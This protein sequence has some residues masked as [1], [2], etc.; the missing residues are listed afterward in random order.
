MNDQWPYHSDT[1]ESNMEQT[2]RI[3]FVINVVCYISDIYSF[4]IYYIFLF[5]FFA[6]HVRSFVSVLVF[7]NELISEHPSFLFSLMW[8]TPSFLSAD[9]SWMVWSVVWHGKRRRA[10]CMTESLR[11]SRP[12]T[13]LFLMPTSHDF[14][15]MPL[16]TWVSTLLS[17]SVKCAEL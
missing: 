10:V 11:Q 12:V 7:I 8:F 13:A 6:F 3:F 4:H 14:L 16:A 17:P 5:V 2:F 15:P 1:L 9:L